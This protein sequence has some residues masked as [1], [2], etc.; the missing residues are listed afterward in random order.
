MTKQEEIN[1][2]I[3]HLQTKLNQVNHI[4]NQVTKWKDIEWSSLVSKINLFLEP[5][6]FGSR[7]G[8]FSK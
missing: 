8:I 6:K 4:E 1:Q 3:Q 5:L 2:E 7:R